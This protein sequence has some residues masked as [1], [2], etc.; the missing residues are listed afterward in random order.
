MQ[1]GHL[2]RKLKHPLP[3]RQTLVRGIRIITHYSVREYTHLTTPFIYV[4]F[5][6]RA[7]IVFVV[8]IVLSFRARAN[9]LDQDV[10]GIEIEICLKKHVG[11]NEERR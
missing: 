10:Y 5:I 8:N 7:F 11:E 1:G 2:E 6:L 3:Q 9:S 4:V